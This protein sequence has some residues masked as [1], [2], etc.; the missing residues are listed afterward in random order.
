MTHPVCVF[1]R[2]RRS[3]HL[4]WSLSL[5]LLLL[6]MVAHAHAAN[7]RWNNGTGSFVFN[8]GA[9]WV[10]GAAPGLLDVAQFGVSGMIQST[11]TV[12][13][14]NNAT[15]QALQ[16]EKDRVTL[17]LSSRQYTLTAAT[18]IVVGNQSGVFP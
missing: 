2:A 14:N 15:N 17:D 5:A 18:G 12:S 7:N 4:R 3:G 13:F 16:I 6:A 1:R 11:Y 8:T 9:N 10:G